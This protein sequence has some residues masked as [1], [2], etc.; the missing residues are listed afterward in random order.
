MAVLPIG[1]PPPKAQVVPLLAKST[2]ISVSNRYLLSKQTDRQRGIFVR[3]FPLGGNL[4]DTLRF[5]GSCW[6]GKPFG[7]PLNDCGPTAGV[8]SVS[9]KPLKEQQC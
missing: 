8:K 5:C 3:I 1:T 2:H 9:M 6:A 4:L 7:M